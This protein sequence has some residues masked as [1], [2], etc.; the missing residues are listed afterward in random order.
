MTTCFTMNKN[1][2][3]Q[4]NGCPTVQRQVSAWAWGVMLALGA[5]QVSLAQMPAPVAVGQTLPALN[6]KDQHDKAWQITPSTRLVMFAAGRKASNLT[7]AVL[8]ALPQDQLSRKNAVSLADM[9]KMP[10]I[11]TRTFAL[12]KLRDLHY[13][14]GV[15]MDETTLAAWPRQTDAVTL[16]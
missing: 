10:G 3:H 9:S 7:Q 1:S 2:S 11:I 13:Q 15:S 12:P 16:I 14:I 5:P 8:K 6:L 4:A